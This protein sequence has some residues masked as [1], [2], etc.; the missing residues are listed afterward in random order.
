MVVNSGEANTAVDVPGVSPWDSLS[1][2]RLLKHAT[3][4]SST[5][6]YAGYAGFATIFLASS[7]RNKRRSLHIM[8]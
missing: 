4:A 6:C 5:D 3:T 2:F 7:L 8:D 1:Q